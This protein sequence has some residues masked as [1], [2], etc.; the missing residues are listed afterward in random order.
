VTAILSATLPATEVRTILSK[1]VNQEYRISI[2][3]PNTYYSGPRRKYP[4][5]YLIDANWYFGL[6]TELTRT[7]SRGP[8]LSEALVVGIGYPIRDAEPLDTAFTQVVALRRNDLTPVVDRKPV[9][10]TAKG[11]NAHSRTGGAGRFLKFIQSELIPVIE[12]NYRVKSAHRILLGHSLGGLF[13]LYA[14][15]QQPRLFSGYVAADPSLQYHDR[16]MFATEERFARAHRALPAKLYL[17]VAEL[18]E[19]YPYSDMVSSTILF[20]ARLESRHYKGFTLTRQIHAGCD[21]GSV[22]APAF[23]AGLQ[24]VLGSAATKSH[25]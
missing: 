13:A 14:L 11:S 16:A 9:K 6:V 4:T 5:V 15:F 1:N 12:A 18:S 2:A 3:L 20:A 24:A 10:S 7:M 19:V 23:Q 25:A 21:H 17:G 8:S 22:V